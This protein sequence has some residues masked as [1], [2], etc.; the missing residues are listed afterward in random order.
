[1]LIMWSGQPAPADGFYVD[2]HGHRLFLRRRE[3]API[4]VY[5]GSAVIRWRLVRPLGSISG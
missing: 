2:E 3:P 1:M 4:C 5:S